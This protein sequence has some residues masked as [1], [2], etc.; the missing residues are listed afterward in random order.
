MKTIQDIKVECKK[1]IKS[2]KE[3]QTEIKLRMRNPGSQP[4]GSD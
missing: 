1:E 4:K 2:L 3:S